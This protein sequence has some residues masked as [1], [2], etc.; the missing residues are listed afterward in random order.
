MEKVIARYA[1]PMTVAINEADARG[2][3]PEWMPARHC[4]FQ[5]A[6]RSIFS[7][8]QVEPASATFSRPIHWDGKQPA[9][10]RLNASAT[11]SSPSLA[12]EIGGS[13]APLHRQFLGRGG[14]MRTLMATGQ[15]PEHRSR[16]LH[17]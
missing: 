17:P 7:L 8:S 1:L 4:D 11:D 13:L 16:G 10:G 9:G 15:L 3:L 2:G 14:S 12:R 6:A 5:E